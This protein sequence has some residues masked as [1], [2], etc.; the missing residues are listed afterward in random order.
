MWYPRAGCWGG[1]KASVLGD[2]ISTF[3]GYSNNPAYNT[4]LTQNSSTYPNQKA[5]VSAAETWWKQ[6]I[7]E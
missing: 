7:R 1:K 6:V 2:S 5:D 3:S 4:T